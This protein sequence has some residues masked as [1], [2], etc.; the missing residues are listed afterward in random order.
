MTAEILTQL[1]R[2][3]SVMSSIASPRLNKKEA[4]KF[5]GYGRERF[6][7]LMKMGKIPHHT[8]A[9]GKTFFLKDELLE[10]LR[11]N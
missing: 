2:I 1:S 10:S 7:L 6:D 4:M 9:F 3:E 8:D 5:M 11:R